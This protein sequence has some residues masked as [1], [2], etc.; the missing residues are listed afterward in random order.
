MMLL[1]AECL[2]ACSF[3]TTGF[4]PQRYNESSAAAAFT[5]GATA[6]CTMVS[7]A[8]PRLAEELLPLSAELGS[9]V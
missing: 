5:A 3:Y 8:W 4:S 2:Q 6:V 7:S 9:A 1:S